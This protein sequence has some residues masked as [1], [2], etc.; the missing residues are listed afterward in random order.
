MTSRLRMPVFALLGLA[1]IAAALWYT[2]R[3]APPTAKVGDCVTAPANGTFK[4]IGCGDSAAKFQVLQRFDG[5]DANQ[6]DKVDGTAAAVR[7]T[8]GSK[9][10]IICLGV[11]K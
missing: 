6:C 5:Q 11:R 10:S 1:V 8:S 2:N 7:E 4:K 3:P 9:Q